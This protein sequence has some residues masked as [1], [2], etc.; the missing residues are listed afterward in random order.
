MVSVLP[1][2]DTIALTSGEQA[3]ST[4]LT[5]YSV[6][7]SRLQMVRGCR[8]DRLRK[9]ILKQFGERITKIDQLTK[10]N[11]AEE[12]EGYPEFLSCGTAIGRIISGVTLNSELGIIYTHAYEL[13]CASLASEPAGEW[14]SISHSS[15]FFARLDRWLYACRAGISLGDLTCFGPVIDVPEAIDFPSVGYWTPD[16]VARAA[17]KLGGSWRSW[18]PWFRNKPPKEL[19]SEVADIR[20]WLKVAQKHKGDALVGV[21]HY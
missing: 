10:G 12:L 16:Q 4:A 18:W 20:R 13:I 1:A 15:D 8:D 6:P 5:V 3:M 9:L 11:V 19:R 2:K 21:H 17:K 14:T 7:F